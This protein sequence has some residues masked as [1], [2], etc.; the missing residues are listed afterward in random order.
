MKPTAVDWAIVLVSIAISF[1]PAILLVRRASSSTTEF[2]TSGRAAPWW[3][4]GFSMV[5]TT[6]STDTPL[7]VTNLV[8]EGGV[9]AN[10]AWWAFL[11][12]GMA[13]V[14]FYARLWRRSRVLTDL[15][16]YELRYSGGPARFV[17]GFRALYLGLFFNCMIMAAVNLAAVKIA[18]VVLG[19]PMLRTLAI[20]TVLNIAFAA[21]SG[22]WGVMVTDTI[23]FVFAMTGSFAAA[24]FA[25]KQPAVG[26]LTGLFAKIPARTAGFLPDFGDWKLTLSLLVIPLTVQWWS[27]WYPGAEPGGGSYIAQR[28][29]AAKSERDAL[30]GT[31]FFNV[32]HYA[33]RP[34]PWIIVALSSM[35]VFPNLSDLA[36]AYP[37]V[38][39]HL[40][41]HDM[42]YSA[43]FKFLPAGFLGIMIAGMR[44]AYESTLSTHLNWG[45][46]YLVH[47]FYRQFVRTDADEK[48]YVLVG[49]ITTGLLMLVAA[50]VTFVLDSARQSFNLLM[51]IGAGTGLIYLLR[52][53]WW[54]INAWS[55]IA[56]MASSFVV[57]IG[58]FVAQ[59]LGVNIEAT[60]VL[61]TTIAVTTVTWVAATYLT[62]PTDQA[63]LERFFALVRP[64]GP[65]WR[66]VRERAR[67]AASPDS[68]A[69]SLLGWVL[70]CTFI[71]AALFGSGAFL[72]RR[73]EQGTLWLVLFV[74]SGVGLAR[75]LPRLWSHAPIASPPTKAVI[76]ARGLGTR[77]R[78][79]DERAEL[80]REQAAMA[81]A[82]VKAMIRID[83][84][85]L[86]Y[87]LSA[88]A[89]AGF[90]DVCL[91]VGPEHDVVRDY[92]ERSAPSRV[93][94]T[95]AVQE[96]PLGTADALLAAASFI[97][98][99]AFVVLN[100]DN[101][102]PVDVLRA[103]RA[104][105]EM[106]LPAFEREALVRDGNISSERIARYA[107]LDIGAD[108]YLRRIVEKPDA[109]SARAFGSDAAV[110]MNV[111]LLT[112]PI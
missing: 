86:D 32:A 11:L 54:R 103:L 83:R 91:V 56:A 16:F 82:G 28:M 71:Y 40:I 57:S 48:H 46:S 97:G 74:A 81:D 105:R 75:L 89:D 109:A 102:Y 33:L 42:A 25:L 6:F 53:F 96:K 87:V 99:D 68:L 8:R 10:W 112:P 24:Y 37:Y 4:I 111:W 72:Y 110:S 34:W 2:F 94:V 30:T 23:Q 49:R 12:T 20:C 63:T 1:T 55:E 15:E 26:G 100:A 52:W 47:D 80:S 73:W 106:A 62:Q 3:L 50:G 95:F 64:P 39:R 69:D 85:F 17:R 21:T 70:G 60:T 65:G 29:L 51:S 18:N 78:A 101:Y 76:L 22:L 13:T 7:L 45:T 107:L 67:L 31:L 88:L 79:A 9:A 92:Y 66:A 98:D 108:G 43:M 59:K 77:M 93:R 44:A 90:T 36:A 19:W 38:D 61:L 27:V 14:F 58:F 5:A 104:Q 35:I 84:P 41:G